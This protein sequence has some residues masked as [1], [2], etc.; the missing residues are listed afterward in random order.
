[1][2]EAA[3]AVRGPPVQQ[4]KP[5]IE[6]QRAEKSLPQSV[7]A[8]AASETFNTLRK[9]YPDFMYKEALL[10]P[11]NP[12][13]KAVEWENDIVNNFRSTGATNEVTGERDTAV[14][15]MLYIARPIQIK[16]IG[17]ASCSE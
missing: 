4:G 5:L 7:P 9:K 11:T 6:Y 3:L 12:R 15:R 2:M 10:N 17:R 14:G 16:E 8:D 13:N 1:M